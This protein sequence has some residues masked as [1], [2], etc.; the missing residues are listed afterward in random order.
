ML[1][2]RESA[3]SQPSSSAATAV[4]SCTSAWASPGVAFRTD[5]LIGQRSFDENPRPAPPGVTGRRRRSVAEH[6]H[7]RGAAEEEVSTPPADDV[8]ATRSEAVEFGRVV[9]PL[10]VDMRLVDVDAGCRD[11]L[12]D[13]HP[14]AEHVDRDLHDRAAEPGRACAPDD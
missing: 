9:A 6:L 12:L 5:T 7:R 8:V 10:A 2:Q 3:S 11:R 13:A 1:R 14:V 4:A